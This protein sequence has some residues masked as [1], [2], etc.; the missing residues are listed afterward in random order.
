VEDLETKSIA[1]E[2]DDKSTKNN[3]HSVR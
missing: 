1:K 3:G 2:M